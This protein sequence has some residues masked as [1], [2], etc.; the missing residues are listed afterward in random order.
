M[1]RA[2]G[3][4]VPVAVA[5]GVTTGWGMTRAGGWLPMGVRAPRHPVVIWS[6]AL[7]IW[8]VLA[9]ASTW[10]TPAAAYLWTLPLLTAAIL[11]VVAPLEHAT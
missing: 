1:V 6:L 8:L 7:P 2:P 4:V 3:S 9:G 5:V 10:F 11:L